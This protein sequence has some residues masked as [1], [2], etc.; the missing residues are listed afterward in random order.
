MDPASAA[1]T[2]VG[3]AGSIAALAGVV[4]ESCKTLNNLWHLLKEAPKDTQRLFKRLKRLATIILELRRVGEELQDDAVG[5][6][7]SQSWL[8]N[9]ADMLSDFNMLKD[10]I[11]RL[12]GNLCARPL[13]KKR[14]CGTIQRIFTHE[15]IVKY[16]QILSGH[17]ETFI[18]MLAL[19]S[20]YVT[21]QHS[22]A[23]ITEC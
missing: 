13:T 15:D 6:E 2:I 5:I 3:F 10:K 12:E 14:L 22:H 20:Q 19:V 16:D 9:V 8:G 4:V 11:M 17:T 23:K 21:P 1:V 7:S 18:I